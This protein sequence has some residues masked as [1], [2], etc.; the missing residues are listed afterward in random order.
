MV[1]DVSSAVGRPVRAQE[2]KDELETAVME[3]SLRHVPTTRHRMAGYY[4]DDEETANSLAIAAKK[5]DDR[6]ENV[7]GRA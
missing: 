5:A 3:G 1:K 7:E 6:H 2:V 4:P